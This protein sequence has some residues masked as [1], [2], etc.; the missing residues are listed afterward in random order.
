M[1]SKPQSLSDLDSLFFLSETPSQPL[2]VLATLVMD[3]SGMSAKSAYELFQERI[4]ERY[5]L[6]EPLRRSPTRSMLGQR[7]WVDDPEIH[8]QRHLHHVLVDSR[9]LEALAE[10]AGDIASHPLPKDR[11]L[12][13]AWLVEGFDERQFAVVAKIH[14]S[15][16]D[17]VSGIFALSGFFDLEPSPAPTSPPR[18]LPNHRRRR[19]HGPRPSTHSFIDRRR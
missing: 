2:H 1:S 9:G 14:H 7:L 6:I 8:I 16:V 18:R 13:E 19:R 4:I 17:G 5:R 3:R 15:A 12:W 11:P 10:V